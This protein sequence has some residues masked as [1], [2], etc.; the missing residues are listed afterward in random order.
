M[1]NFKKTLN[2]ISGVILAGLV[3]FLLAGTIVSEDIFADSEAGQQIPLFPIPLRWGM[4]REEVQSVV[5]KHGL[6]LA[7]SDTK[8]FS[9]RKYH[10]GKFYEWA[11]IK[12]RQDFLGPRFIVFGLDESNRLV[13]I[14]ADL[15]SKN[16]LDHMNLDSMARK[17]FGK[18]YRE[19]KKKSS[20]GETES[21][22][23]KIKN[24]TVYENTL[25]QLKS[26]GNKLES[27]IILHWDN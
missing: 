19:E 25:Y 8:N 9:K 13:Y 14:R 26:S 3:F 4:T 22:A 17:H 24:N 20:I 15:K 23:W 5:R 21:N 7:I 18:P 11:A 16:W 27:H 2:R 1:Q 10:D 6:H 12:E